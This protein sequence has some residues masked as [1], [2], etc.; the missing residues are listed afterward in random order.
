[1][2]DVENPHGVLMEKEPLMGASDKGIATEVLPTPR[3][4]KMGKNIVF[5]AAL[6]LSVLAVNALKTAAPMTSASDAPILAT[7]DDNAGTVVVLLTREYANEECT[8]QQLK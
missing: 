7:D 1:M 8:A 5:A 2:K 3:E 6:A 4:N